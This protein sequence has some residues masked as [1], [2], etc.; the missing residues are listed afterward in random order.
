MLGQ[1]Y[2]ARTGFCDAHVSAHVHGKNWHQADIDGS[3]SGCPLT[4]G[5]R[6]LRRRVVNVF[7]VVVSNRDKLAN[8]G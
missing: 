6:T 2:F 5:K 7:A 8:E 1:V 3:A 4:G